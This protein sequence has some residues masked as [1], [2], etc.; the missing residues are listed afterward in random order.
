MER[1][2]CMIPFLLPL[3]EKVSAQP[4]DEGS[5]GVAGTSFGGGAK[6]VGQVFRP[7]IRPA[8]QAAFSHKGRR[9]T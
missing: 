2:M 6:P 5:R 3:R 8:P 4:T 7:L 1:G 9:K